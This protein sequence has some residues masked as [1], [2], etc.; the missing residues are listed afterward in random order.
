MQFSFLSKKKKKKSWTQAQ[1]VGVLKGCIMIFFSFFNKCCNHSNLDSPN[2][3]S[4]NS[5]T[6]ES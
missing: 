3:I 1:N 2:S 4:Q 6:I 5:S